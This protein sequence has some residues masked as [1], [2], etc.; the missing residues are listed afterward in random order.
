MKT[1]IDAVLIVPT[2]ILTDRCLKYLSRGVWYAVDSHPNFSDKFESSMLVLNTEAILNPDNIFWN[3]LEY[4]TKGVRRKAQVKVKEQSK[5]TVLL[6]Y[7]SQ[8]ET[9]V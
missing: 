4:Y 7:K 8:C 9:V 1:Q 2:H 6:F 3:E 5:L